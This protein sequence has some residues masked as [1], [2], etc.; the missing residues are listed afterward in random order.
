MHQQNLFNAIR[1]TLC[2]WAQIKYQEKPN[3]IGVNLVKVRTRCVLGKKEF[4]LE[5]LIQPEF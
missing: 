2:P 5:I 3:D 1:T 4:F